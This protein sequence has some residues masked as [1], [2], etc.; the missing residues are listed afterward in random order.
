VGRGKTWHESVSV[1][2]AQVKGSDTS[3][4]VTESPT[5]QTADK[6]GPDPALARRAVKTA[7]RNKTV[8]NFSGSNLQRHYTRIPIAGIVFASHFNIFNSCLVFSFRLEF[9]YEL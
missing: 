6:S 7:Q 1:L 5:S 2:L 8:I 9:V 3:C 4:C